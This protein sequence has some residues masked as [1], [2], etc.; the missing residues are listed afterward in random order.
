MI[1]ITDVKHAYSVFKNIPE[2]SQYLTLE[3]MLSRIGE[4]KCLSLIFLANDKPVGFK[5]GYE[6]NSNEFYSWLGGVEPE[7][8]SRGIAHRLL[9][10]QEKWV[11]ENGYKELSVKSMNRFP[12]MMCMLL[13][14]GYIIS[15]ITPNESANKSK[16]HFI[17][18]I[19]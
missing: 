16:I 3:Q 18:K 7:F 13:S 5:L 11:I 8:R 9:L 2:F 19:R 1:L 4:S 6:I 17:K 14:N 12:E 15:G 10:E